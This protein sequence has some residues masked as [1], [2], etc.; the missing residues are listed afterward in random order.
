MHTLSVY[1][2]P[3]RAPTLRASRRPAGARWGSAGAGR[4]VRASCPVHPRPRDDSRPQDCTTGPM[5]VLC[6]FGL[7][8]QQ[9]ANKIQGA[10]GIALRPK[11]PETMWVASGAWPRPSLQPAIAGASKA[12]LL[13]PRAHKPK[14][15]VGRVWSASKT[16]T[17]GSR[18]S[19]V[20]SKK[21]TTQKTH[22][23]LLRGGG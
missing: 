7:H 13:H 2:S 10:T 14:P 8:V 5:W 22:L 17:T 4:V 19:T 3:A 18:N 12:F 9:V 16:Q 11:I 21:R 1:A 23:L 20:R 6:P 15:V